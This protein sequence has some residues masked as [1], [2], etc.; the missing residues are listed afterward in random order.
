MASATLQYAVSYSVG[1]YQFYY[2]S[3]YYCTV[4]TVSGNFSHGQHFTWKK[5]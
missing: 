3:C 2:W 5:L 4:T 1:L